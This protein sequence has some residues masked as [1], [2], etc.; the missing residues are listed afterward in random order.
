VKAA[1]PATGVPGK[2]HPVLPHDAEH[3]LVVDRRLARAGQLSV[4][5]GCEAA[6]AISR[7][8]VDQAADERQQL[9]IFGLAVGTARL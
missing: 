2:Q 4:G 6:I 5:Q 7:A 9:A 8:L 3:A 1:D